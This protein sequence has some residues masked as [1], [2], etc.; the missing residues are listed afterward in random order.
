M[1]ALLPA[2]YRT[3]TGD[4][5]GDLA[6]PRPDDAAFLRRELGLGRLAKLEKWLWIAGR[7]L[8]PRPLHYQRVL[9]RD[10]V[11]V[12]QMDL[13][14]VWTAGQIYVKPVPRF[15]LEPDFWRDHLVDD[16]DLGPAALGFLFS[17]A[18]LVRHESDFALAREKRL[19]PAGVRWADWRAFVAELLRDGGTG[20]G[21]GRRIYDRVDARFHYGELRLSRLNK[22]RFLHTGTA[23]LPPWDRYTDFFRDNF[24]WL[25]ATTVYIA[26]VLTAMQVGI[27]TKALSEDRAFH[28]ASYGFTVFSILGPLVGAF[29]IL[30][31]FLCVF[32]L[33]WVKTLGFRNRRLAHVR[34]PSG[35]GE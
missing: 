19:I 12:E 4:A 2:L 27:S 35:F 20:G 8:P 1:P 18:A 11:V 21:G 26:V 13:H 23:Y 15:L 3:G 34:G 29:L 14:L 28:A 6:P 24:A 10:I 33:N 30:A 31:V 22:L 16:P 7:P 32:V 17:Y 25:A 5:D 9:R